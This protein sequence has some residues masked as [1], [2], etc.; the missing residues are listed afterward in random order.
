MEN[1]GHDRGVFCH[2]YRDDGG[3]RRAVRRRRCGEHIAP[4]C[5]GS[6]AAMAG[7]WGAAWRGRGDPFEHSP[8]ITRV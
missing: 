8:G 6:V 7:V 1:G 3:L 5:V 4:A 2:A